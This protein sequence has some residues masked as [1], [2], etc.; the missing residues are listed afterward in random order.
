MPAG[1]LL[2]LHCHNCSGTPLSL[3]ISHFPAALVPLDG[4]LP[5]SINEWSHEIHAGAQSCATK[6]ANKQTG[7]PI[8][9]VMRTSCIGTM[10]EKH[11]MPFN[12]PACTHRL[13][14]IEQRTAP[15]ER[16]ASKLPI[17][18]RKP[19]FPAAPS[20]CE[21]APLPPDPRSPEHCPPVF[22]SVPTTIPRQQCLCHLA[23][24]VG[25]EYAVCTNTR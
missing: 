20:S 8:G 23:H 25:G 17:E 5:S 10:H 2:L 7:M 24:K 4:A 1:H 9:T 16:L 6:P 13:Q 15:S 19:T 3:S 18:Q 21:T 14:F 11:N 12:T 22:L